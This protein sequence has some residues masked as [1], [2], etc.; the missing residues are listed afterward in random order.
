MP[1]SF[2]LQLHDDNRPDVSTSFASDLGGVLWKIDFSSLGP[3]LGVGF[4]G[5]LAD[6]GTGPIPNTSGWIE[7]RLKVK[8]FYKVSG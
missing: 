7:R 5:T 2:R 4:I 6:F 3:Q 1:P 8:Q